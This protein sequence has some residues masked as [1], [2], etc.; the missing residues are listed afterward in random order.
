M[1][2]VLAVIGAGIVAAATGTREF[3]V[4]EEDHAELAPEGAESEG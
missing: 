1:S 2:L 4:H 3:E